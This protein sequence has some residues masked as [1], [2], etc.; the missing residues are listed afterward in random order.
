MI[1]VAGD[2]EFDEGNIFEAL[3]ESM[4]HDIRN[5]W[6]IVDYNRQ[7]LDAVIPDRFCYRLDNMFRGM[8]WRVI[9][10]KYGT[11][12]EKAFLRRGGDA[13]RE[14]IDS[15]PN[16]RYSALAYKGGAAWREQLLRELGDTSGIRELL[17]DHD[18]ESLHRLMTNLA[19]HD[20][21]SVLD[22]FHGAMDDQPT[23][24]IAYTIK[25]YGLP[26][27]GH[28]DNHAGMMTPEQVEIF[29]KRIGVGDGRGVGPFA[30]LDVPEHE[31]RAFLASVPFA[32]PAT[33]RHDAQ[34]GGGPG[35]VRRRR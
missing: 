6:W 14:W 35:R 10:L 13:L 28:K 17:D 34:P 3:L 33:R 9:T 11:L 26:F 31:L 24:F 16:S 4:K 22:A 2:A 23:C 21:E 32:Q 5:V 12:L 30:G 1:A 29:K 20:L 25:G 19:G 8:D 15:C 7:S 18:D 27:A